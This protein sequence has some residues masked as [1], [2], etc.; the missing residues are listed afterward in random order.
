VANTAHPQQSSFRSIGMIVIAA[1]LG[2]VAAF[3]LAAL[4]FFS[5]HADSPDETAW[6]FWALWLA[7][8]GA[9]V[10]FA[11]SKRLPERPRR[12][13]LRVFAVVGVAMALGW[14]GLIVLALQNAV[15][16]PPSSPPKLPPPPTAPRE[17]G[18]GTSQ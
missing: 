7:G 5:W 16:A 2:G 17:G 3:P 10:L 13:S 1:V 4:T 9:G 11:I 18:D 15:K 12:W 14:G 6:G 8:A